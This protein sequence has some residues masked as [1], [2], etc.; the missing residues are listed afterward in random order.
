MG[1]LGGLGAILSGGD[2]VCRLEAQPT[3]NRSG[4]NSAPPA[5]FGV[6][7]SSSAFVLRNFLLPTMLGGVS[8]FFGNW[9]FFGGFGGLGGLEN[10][11]G[12]PGPKIGQKHPKSR[13][14]RCC[15]PFWAKRPPTTFDRTLNVG[16]VT[17]FGV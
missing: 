8:Q 13:F 4:R 9:Q 16:A 7:F 14:S 2:R 6:F 1:V 17:P 15:G 12:R 10:F 11:C 5:S 3:K